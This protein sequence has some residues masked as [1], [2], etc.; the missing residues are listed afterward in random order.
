MTFQDGFNVQDFPWLWEPWFLYWSTFNMTRALLPLI[1]RDFHRRHICHIVTRQDLRN[2]RLTTVGNSLV[3][4]DLCLEGSMT[5]LYQDILNVNVLRAVCVAKTQRHDPLLA[6]KKMYSNLFIQIN[7]FFIHF[8]EGRST[9]IS[10]WFERVLNNQHGVELWW[11]FVKH[12]ARGSCS[13]VLPWWS[14]K[15][16]L[17]EVDY[18]SARR[19]AWM[20]HLTTAA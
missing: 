8:H 14:L 15:R 19:C 2:I 18:S 17:S 1:W 13:Q 10:Y 12:V 9:N 4:L 7:S 20:M 11:N 5:L 16:V 6:N 3:V